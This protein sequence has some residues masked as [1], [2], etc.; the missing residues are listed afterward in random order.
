MKK[1]DAKA[2][3]KKAK[4]ET[5]E[6]ALPHRE[7]TVDEI[8]DRYYSVARSVLVL[9]GSEGHPIVTRPFNYEAEVRRKKDL[10]KYMMRTK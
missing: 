4:K 3:G 10:E 9:R 2:R 5:C 6:V 8:K 1:R 7:R